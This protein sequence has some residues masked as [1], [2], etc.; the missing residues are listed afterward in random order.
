MVNSSIIGGQ[1]YNEMKRA[2]MISKEIS[3]L[4]SN[5]YNLTTNIYNLTNDEADSIEKI[6]IMIKKVDT[7]FSELLITIKNGED[8]KYLLNA[9][10]AWFEYKE[11]LT[12]EII[13]AAEANNRFKI[14]YLMTGIEHNR[15]TVINSN[16]LHVSEEI[17]KRFNIVENK[18]LNGSAIKLMLFIMLS[19]IIILFITAISL[20]IKLLKGTYG[21]NYKLFQ[22]TSK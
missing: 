13:P 15:A 8:R 20:I 3:T 14:N 19:S 2:L 1:N 18:L 9:Q 17:E 10:K 12:E 21:E 22:K 6:D 16:I 11:T 5:F 4:K 7:N